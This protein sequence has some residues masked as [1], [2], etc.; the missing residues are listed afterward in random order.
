MLKKIEVTYGSKVVDENG[1]VVCFNL[2]STFNGYCFKDWEAFE[3][4]DGICYISEYEFKDM[5]E[6]LAEL[7][8]CYK[9]GTITEK[10]F[11]KEC[12]EVINNTGWTFDE[13]LNCCGGKGFEYLAEIVFDAIDWQSPTTYINEIEID[14]FINVLNEHGI[15]EDM[16]RKGGLID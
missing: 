3:K 9:A 6:H 4:R 8:E 5:E 1:E 15:T 13:I 16:L 12:I 10:E 14:D 2:G 7:K 11:N